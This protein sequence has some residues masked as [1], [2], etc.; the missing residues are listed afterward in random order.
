M[1]GLDDPYYV[2]GAPAAAATAAPAAAQA[3]AMF[4]YHPG[5]GSG[6]F[7][8]LEELFSHPLSFAE[9]AIPGVNSGTLPTGPGG[10][11]GFVAGLEELAQKP[12]TFVGDLLPSW[13]TTAKLALIGGL[14]V[15][16]ILGIAYTAHKV[17]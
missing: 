11:S 17:L 6:F 10:G 9:D 16:G 15:A 4:S 12:G 2:N 5:G 7:A 8:G 3:R 13:G 1:F 14:A